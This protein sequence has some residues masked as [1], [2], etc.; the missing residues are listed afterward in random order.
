MAGIILWEDA[1]VKRLAFDLPWQEKWVELGHPTG[2]QTA[3]AGDVGAARFPQ[4]G[5]ALQ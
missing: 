4:L 5:E 2:G 3:W 1:F